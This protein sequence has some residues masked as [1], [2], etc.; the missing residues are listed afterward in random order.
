MPLFVIG[1]CYSIPLAFGSADAPSNIQW[2]SVAGTRANDRIE[3][4]N[5]RQ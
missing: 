5:F 2:L 3:R 1:F 4:R